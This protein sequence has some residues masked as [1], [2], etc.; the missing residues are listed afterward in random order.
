MKWGETF[1]SWFSKPK[2]AP[3]ADE[4]VGAQPSARYGATLR[5][6]QRVVDAMNRHR[7]PDQLTP[8]MPTPMP[9][10]P[11]VR[12]VEAP[13]EDW[14]GE[15]FVLPNDRTIVQ[16][17]GR[18]PHRQSYAVHNQSGNAVPV[19]LFRSKED[20]DRFV[21]APVRPT[22]GRFVVVPADPANPRTGTQSGGVWA[23]VHP[24]AA[25][26]AT[27]DV[28]ASVYRAPRG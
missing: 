27:I 17:L 20:A 9:D 22:E 10:L 5:E 12:E 21:N 15:T 14:Y 6:D 16:I 26:A 13:P 28:T 3:P 8:T 7:L 18:A 11:I 2:A 19:F 4:L 1:M 24:T 25:G 23:A